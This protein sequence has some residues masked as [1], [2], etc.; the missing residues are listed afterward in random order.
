MN[1][2]TATISAISTPRGKGGVALIRLSG[3]DA[4]SVASRM[5]RPKSGRSLADCAPR[6]AV[7]GTILDSDDRPCDEGIV[8][9]FCGPHSFTGED[10]AEIA[11]HGG[12]AVTEAVC[13]STFAHGASAAGPGEFTRRAFVNGRLSLT[14]AEAVGRLIDADTAERLELSSGA[15][16]GNVSREIARISDTLLSTMT[17]LYAAIDYPEE[18]V[19]DEGE[20]EIAATLGAG[21]ADVER[22]LSTYKV[23]RAV[24]DGVR[25]VLCGRPNVGKSSVF[26]LMT[27]EE[28]AIVTEIA[29]TTRDVL[30]ETVSFGG[31]TLRLSDTAG[32][33]A[34]SDIVER[35]GVDR[36]EGEIASAE[37]ILALF[38]GSEPLTEED[39]RLLDLLRASDAAKIAVVN[40]EDA[41]LRLTDGELAEIDAACGRRVTLSAKSGDGRALADEIAALYGSGTLDLRADAV[42]WD[43]RQRQAL[44]R[45]KTALSEACAAIR[46]GDPIDCVCTLAEEAMAALNETDGRGID[47]T[48]VGEIFKR[49]CVG[50]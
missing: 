34:T 42:I 41:G 8:T 40:K 29:G 48:I 1:D 26:N 5:F 24:A 30:R 17:A 15:L 38:D 2:L 36:A 19:G 9:V 27:G 32:V 23:G 22:L 21:L 4:V 12:P 7:F 31:V 37:L 3:P 33:R 18:D 28:S 25:T 13:L 46:R 43:I 45:A 20:R 10:V 35:I 11:C 16:R 50:K 14:E 6:T 49:F 39:R 44:E 47:E